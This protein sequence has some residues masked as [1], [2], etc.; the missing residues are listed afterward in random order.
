MIEP[1]FPRILF[2]RKIDLVYNS[3]SYLK[4]TKFFKIRVQMQDIAGINC[5][6]QD[7]QNLIFYA[8]YFILQEILDNR[9]M[10]NRC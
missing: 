9:R 8:G 4:I 6:M 10:Q 7:K 1:I 5:R 3:C 2:E